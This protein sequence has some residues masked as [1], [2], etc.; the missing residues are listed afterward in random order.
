M[1]DDLMELRDCNL[2]PL[3]SCK[4]AQATETLK[5]RWFELGAGSELA[6]PVKWWVHDCGSG[7]GKVLTLVGAFAQDI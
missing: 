6:M 5:D 7:T 4:L 3:G 2:R 1:K